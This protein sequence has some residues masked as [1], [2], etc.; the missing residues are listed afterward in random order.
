MLLMRRINVKVSNMLTMFAMTRRSKA[1]AGYWEERKW[2]DGPISTPD[3]IYVIRRSDKY[4]G[5]LSNFHHVLGHVRRA[6]QLG[7]IPVVD[8]Q[9]YDWIQ[10]LT[11]I[12]RRACNFW[13]RVFEQPDRLTLD[14]AYQYKNIVLSNGQFPHKYYPSSF[15]HILDNDSNDFEIIS[16][17]A[18]DIFKISQT[19][20]L[21]VNKLLSNILGKTS[22]IAIWGRG[23]DYKSP[24]VGHIPAMSAD[25]LLK[26]ATSQA[27]KLSAN[28]IFLATE[29]E[30]ILNL[31][32]KQ[33][34]NNVLYVERP[35]V[36]ANEDVSCTPRWKINR[37]DHVYKTAI[38]YLAEVIMCSS[39][40]W[41]SGSLSNG[42]ALALQLHK[43]GRDAWVY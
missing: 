15:Q 33:L 4:G 12:E 27:E 18:K 40:D 36:R 41:I 21:E 9:D 3:H 32:L 6:R 29:E 7:W 10:G 38:E 8:T 13:E 14:E 1:S 23:T 26:L 11:T 16:E 17:L 2:S 22:T 42:M 30:E 25:K 19:A 43:K 39:S 5:L 28:Y 31:F 35:R 20:T 37:D 24:P 34:G